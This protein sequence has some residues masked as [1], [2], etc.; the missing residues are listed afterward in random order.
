MG[1]ELAKNEFQSLTPA[2]PAF[3]GMLAVAQQREIAEVQSK[4]IIARS[5]P[6]DERAALDRILMACGR[7][8]LAESA[9]YTYS[10]GGT[11]ITGPSIRLA[12]ALAQNWGNLDFGIREI[13]QRDGES[14]VEAYAWDLQTNTRQNKVFQVPHIRYSKAKG[15]T[16]LTDPRDIYELIANQGARRLRACILGVIPGDVTEAATRQCEETMKTHVKVTPELLQSLL[17]KFAEYH[18]TKEQIEARI[19]RRMDAITPAQVVGL[20]KIYNSLKDGMSTAAEWFADPEA[21][22]KSHGVVNIDEI[23]GGS[24]NRGHGKEGLGAAS[25]KADPKAATE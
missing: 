19:Q 20:G 22:N 18:V 16:L 6:R 2:A 10:R 13:E 23:K 21:A 9:L 7:K 4:M 14:T 11:E 24:E 5:C 8:T 12:E 17:D 3:S 15:N 1:T 25:K